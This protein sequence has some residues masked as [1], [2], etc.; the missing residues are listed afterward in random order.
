MFPQNWTRPN[1]LILLPSKHKIVSVTDMPT[2]PGQKTENPQMPPWPPSPQS[3]QAASPQTLTLVNSHLHCSCYGVHV[4][5]SFFLQEKGK[6][7][8][9]LGSLLPFLTFFNTNSNLGM[10]NSPSQSSSCHGPGSPSHHNLI[11]WRPCQRLELFTT[12]IATLPDRQGALP[13]V[14][15]P[16]TFLCLGKCC[17]LSRDWL[18]PEQQ[19]PPAHV[20]SP[21]LR[22][23]SISH[24]SSDM[25][26]HP[27]HTL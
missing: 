11:V 4:R 26:Y 25:E 7:Q 27:T 9:F 17:A 15:W 2:G 22:L 1:Q 21:P 16:S 13:A 10:W 23:D 12:H 14:N 24:Q 19:P 5:D 3:N 8:Q 6:M 20:P 18:V